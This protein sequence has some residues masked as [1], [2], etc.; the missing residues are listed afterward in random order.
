MQINIDI[1]KN[2]FEEY[3]ELVNNLSKIIGNTKM[4][5]NY[6]YENILNKLENNNKILEKDKELLKPIYEILC[7]KRNKLELLYGIAYLDIEH[8]IVKNNLIT[9]N[10]L[11]LFICSYIMYYYNIFMN[12]YE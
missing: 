9:G 8:G 12:N 1:D 2:D 10:K 4:T 3:V 5:Y 11:N 7:N 6:I